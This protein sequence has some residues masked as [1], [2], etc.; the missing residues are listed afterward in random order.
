MKDALEKLREFH[1][2]FNCARR[3]TPGFPTREERILRTSLMEEEWNELYT[4]MAKEDMEGV[5]DGLADLCY[6]VIGTAVAYGIP[7]D[8]VFEEVHRS[9]MEKA[10]ACSTCLG[11]G[12]IPRTGAS[13]IRKCPVCNGL[14]RIVLRRPDGKVLK[15]EGWQPPNIHAALYPSEEK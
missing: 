8:R 2:V 14:G 3:D 1:R 13:G 4:A 5:A 9:N 12:S 7:L 11:A 10:V 6:V 15:P